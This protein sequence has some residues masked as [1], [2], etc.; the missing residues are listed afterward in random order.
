ME[1]V[2][3]ADEIQPLRGKAREW[4]LSAKGSV[5][6][7]PGETTDDARMDYYAAK[8][9]ELQHPMLLEAEVGHLP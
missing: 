8:Y 4:L 5:Q 3:H 7:L 1:Q 9:T 6:L 2:R